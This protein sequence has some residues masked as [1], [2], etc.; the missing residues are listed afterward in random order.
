MI[1]SGSIPG[2]SVVMR[3]MLA[4]NCVECQVGS[5]EEICKTEG[6]GHLNCTYAIQL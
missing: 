1:L 3:Y 5:A 2:I 4:V 6:Y